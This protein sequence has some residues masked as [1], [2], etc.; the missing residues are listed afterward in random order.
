MPI[1]PTTTSDKAKFEFERGLAHLVRLG[2]APP[3]LEI[4]SHAQPIYVLTVAG[5]PDLRKANTPSAF[6][7]FATNADGA[8]VVGEVNANPPPTIA[9]LR[10][11]VSAKKIYVATHAVAERPEARGGNFYLR[12]LRI[13]GALTEAFW[14]PEVTGA[15]GFIVPFGT[16]FEPDRREGK[17]L[18]IEDFVKTLRPVGEPKRRMG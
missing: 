16:S 15:D 7:Y 1:I 13:P 2:K 8:V 5:G 17:P 11:G 6:R 4:D 14:L 18:G 12:V 10:Y 3:D 9:N